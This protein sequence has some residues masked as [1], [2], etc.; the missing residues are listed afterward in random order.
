MIFVDYYKIL[1]VDKTATTADIKNAYRKL[2]C[3]GANSDHSVIN[4][5][6]IILPKQFLN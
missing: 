6:G 5:C 3:N 4:C 2:A 1:G